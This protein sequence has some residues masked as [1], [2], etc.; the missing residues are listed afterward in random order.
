MGG[1]QQAT[2]AGGGEAGARLLKATERDLQ[3]GRRMRLRMVLKTAL[4][5]CT[6]LLTRTQ[7]YQLV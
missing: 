5:E 4:R 3:V 6:K 1:D 2:G 7:N